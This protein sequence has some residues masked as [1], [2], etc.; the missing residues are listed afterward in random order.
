MPVMDSGL[1]PPPIPQRN[2]QHVRRQSVPAPTTQPKSNEANR[3]QIQPASP[4][5]I[6]SLITSLSIISSP[7][8]ELF[9]QPDSFSPLF[10]SPGASYSSS[11]GIDR[12]SY[13]KGTSKGGSFGIDYG[14][15]KQPSLEE[16]QD[17]GPLDELAA[18]PPVIRTAKPPSGFSPLTAPKSP[19]KDGGIKTFLRGSSRPTSEGSNG[20]KEH[21]EVSS[22]GSL[23]IEPGV[24][25]QTELRKR[26]SSD[27][28]GKKQSRNSK[29]LM[30]MSS[31][32]RLRETERKRASVAAVGGAKGLGIDRGPPLQSETDSFLAERPISEE[33]NFD[34]TETSIPAAATTAVPTT[35]EVGSVSPALSN[36][37]QAGI[38]SPRT[39]PTRESSLRV[40]S[41]N[42]KRSSN[43]SSRQSGK[44]REENGDHMIKE[45]DEQ[46][47][48]RRERNSEKK[49]HDRL[50]VSTDTASK[51]HQPLKSPLTPEPP[52]ASALASKQVG[53][54]V[55]VEQRLVAED[56]TE[57]PG[58]P[59]PA[60]AQRKSRTSGDYREGALIKTKKTGRNTP[61]ILEG[62]QPKRES[63]LKRL[64]APLSPTGSSKENH[65]RST[66]QPLSR[67]EV[68][69]P[70]PTKPQI[71][72]DD[73]PTSADSIDG[74]V[75]SY[76][77]S[78]RLS[79]K[80]RHPQTG[81]TIS[82]SEVGDPEGYAVF[83]CV[84]M[85]LTRYITAFYDELALTLKLR[86]ITPDR[87][88][89]GDSEAYTDGTATPL[90]WPGKCFPNQFH[91]LS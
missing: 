8:N 48:L 72:L 13:N 62:K 53:D 38:A 18:S 27:S 44:Q 20:S 71:N 35:P 86:L 52:K 69:S 76:L 73:R 4:E 75:E 43:R 46:E 54:G 26:R 47:D 22:I 64:S 12:H 65:Q 15:F 39:I 68:V 66:S 17:D 40:S 1:S 50:D 82:F 7:V 31:K 30:Y 10:S 78:P 59:S 80:I 3:V 19:A 83:C 5:V 57:E 79:Q 90:S 88:G 63:K 24:A 49:R 28:W 87:P 42:R 25:P 16:V 84:G 61:D 9:E 29:G 14:A 41:T 58:A 91:Y 74:A 36:T 55:K 6:S 70:D 89:V 37:S 77:C 51:L 85:G 21:D 32:E 33:T 45:V 2:R 34:H 11:G 60:I 23:S 67:K 81:R 56:D